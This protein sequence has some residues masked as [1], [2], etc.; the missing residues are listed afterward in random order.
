MKKIVGILFLLALAFASCSD[1]DD[2]IANLPDN[3]ENE[4][5]VSPQ[6]PYK[7]GKDLSSSAYATWDNK[8]MDDKYYMLGY[9]YDATGKYAHPASVR[10]KVLNFEVYDKDD[11]SVLFSKSTS[12]GP[13]LFI[14]GT[15]RECVQDLAKK[16]GF[17]TT[18]ISKYRNLFKGKFDS[19]FKNDTS[20][21]ELSY[22]YHGVSQINVVYHLSFLYSTYRKDR[23]QSSYLTNNFK[24]DLETKSAEEILKIYGT[25]IL[26]SILIGERMDYLYRYAADEKSSSSDWFLYNTHRYFSQGPSAWTSS[27]KKDPPLKEN[28]Y[29]EVVDGTRPNPNTWMVDITNFQGKRIEFNG[30]KS[31]TDNSLT[32][33]AFRNDDGLIPIYEF[34]K[35]PAKREALTKAYE[36]YLSE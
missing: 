30:W 27:P 5:G 15:Q 28:M 17:S 8:G 1:H 11:G 21:P 4:E 13:E 19:P 3:N 22:Y 18:E 7:T 31:I 12:S 35:D 14:A 34:V 16:A 6:N 20:F 36:K 2:D 10:N 29:I 9:G 23:F 24:A 32:L 33:V 26:S 25:H